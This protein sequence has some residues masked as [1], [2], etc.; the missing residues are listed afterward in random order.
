MVLC[1]LVCAF[2]LQAKAT[3]YVAVNLVPEDNISDTWCTL[4]SETLDQFY[5]SSL[6]LEG[7]VSLLYILCYEFA[8]GVS[9]LGPMSAGIGSRPPTTPF[10]D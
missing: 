7:S 8:Q 3:Q 10:R 5:A 2:S 9:C 1:V 4:L 6:L